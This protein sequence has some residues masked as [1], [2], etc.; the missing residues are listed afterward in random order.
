MKPFAQEWLRSLKGRFVCLATAFCRLGQRGTGSVPAPHNVEM[1]GTVA[2]MTFSKKPFNSSAT[3][4]LSSPDQ[5]MKT[6]M[7]ESV[8]LS[9]YGAYCQVWFIVVFWAIDLHQL[10]RSLPARERT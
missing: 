1:N 7:P 6:F 10:F 5:L 2:G 4:L 9:D 3:F 8:G